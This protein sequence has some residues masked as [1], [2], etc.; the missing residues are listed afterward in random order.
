MKVIVVISFS[1]YYVATC[2]IWQLFLLSR[3]WIN[4]IIWFLSY[5]KA[6]PW[7]WMLQFLS[8]KCLLNQQSQKR[9]SKKSCGYYNMVHQWPME[10]GSIKSPMGSA[11]R[12]SIGHSTTWVGVVNWEK[13]ALGR[14]FSVIFGEASLSRK[15]RFGKVAK[16]PSWSI[17]ESKFLAWKVAEMPSWNWMN[18]LQKLGEM[19]SL[20]FLQAEILSQNFSF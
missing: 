15:I 4:N 14:R 11:F 13:F 18:Q 7:D 9:P 10:V 1:T 2:T 3:F 6:L 20:F 8:W 16:I 12:A 17:F 19:F 5:K